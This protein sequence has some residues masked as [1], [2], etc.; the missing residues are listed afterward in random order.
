[1]T[2]RDRE[3]GTAETT[4]I[5]APTMR[6][7]DFTVQSAET[8]SQ[9]VEPTAASAWSSSPLGNP[10]GYEGLQGPPPDYYSVHPATSA[11][12]MT[13]V[14][15]GPMAATLIGALSAGA[16][17]GVV[18]FAYVSLDEPHSVAVAPGAVASK[19]TP[20]KIP[21]F[22][23]AANTPAPPAAAPDNGPSTAAPAPVIAPISSPAPAVYPHPPAVQ[24]GPPPPPPPADLPP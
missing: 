17:L 1:M 12:A 22:A 23:P 6:S 14:G 11:T 9:P 3:E 15:K 19:T 2:N 13:S 10:G 5:S 7:A 4:W 24:P 16:A 18:V 21:A 8:T 20:A